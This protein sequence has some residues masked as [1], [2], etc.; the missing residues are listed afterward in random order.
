MPAPVW[1]ATLNVKELEIAGVVEVGNGCDNDIAGAECSTTSVLSEDAISIGSNSYSVTDVYTQSQSGWLYL[2]IDTD[3]GSIEDLKALFFCV[4]TQEYPLS[5]LSSTDG[6]ATFVVDAALTVGDA[7][8]LSIR[9]SCTPSQ[10]TATVNTSVTHVKLTASGADAGW[11]S[12]QMGPTGGSHDIVNHGVPST[13]FALALGTNSL[14]ARTTAQDSTTQKDYTIVI[15]QQEQPSTTVSL[16]AA[17]G[18]GGGGFQRHGDG[19]PVGGPDQ[20]RDHPGDR[21]QQHGGVRRPRDPDQHHHRRRRHRRHGDHHHEPG[22][23]HRRRALHRSLG[24]SLPS[25]ITAGRHSSVGVVIA[26]A[27]GSGAVAATVWTGTLSTG[28]THNGILGC[29]LLPDRGANDQ[30][31]YQTCHRRFAEVDGQP[32]NAFDHGGVD[33]QV[34]SVF[35]STAYHGQQA[36]GIQPT[37][38][39]PRTGCWWW[40]AAPG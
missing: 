12:L 5:L 23:G 9:S 38:G 33:Y 14:T 21:H 2:Q 27:A 22:H 19:H 7:V 29:D 6:N 32:G 26:D 37:G 20:C 35:L 18:G 40:T 30:N 25:G 3:A 4:G 36:F 13:A 1:S 10:Y 31:E 8:L 17:P 34:L 15:T 28:E 16:S 39:C 24:T 11:Q